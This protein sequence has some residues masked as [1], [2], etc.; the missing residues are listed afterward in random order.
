M[1]LFV[2]KF[3]E[4]MKNKGYGARK[5][6]DQHKN[7]DYVRKCYKCK[8]KDRIVADCLYNSDNDEDEKKKKK[9]VNKMTFKRKKGGSYVVT[10]DSDASSD[11]DDCSDDE[12]K[13]TKKKALVSI[14]IKNKPSLFDMLHG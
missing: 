10:W 11:S 7:K 14:A 8:S 9:K 3:G 6:R 1:A 5:R 13:T 12:K 2:R 4:F